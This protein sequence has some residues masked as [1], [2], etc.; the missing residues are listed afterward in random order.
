MNI[1]AHSIAASDSNIS[2]IAGD[3]ERLCRSI[4]PLS[5]VRAGDL[6]FIG[7]K[8]TPE[9]IGGAHLAGATAVCNEAVA[10]MI[11][12]EQDV[13]L[14]VTANARLAFMRAARTFFTHRGPAAG[15]HPSAV[16]AS[17]AVVDPTAY[18]GPGVVVGAGSRIGPDAII[19]PN[20]V[21]YDRVTIG[22]RVI[23]NAGTV[24][25]AD[26]F[27]YERNEA[28]ELEKFPHLGGVVIEDD[29][30]IGS[31]TSIDRGTLGDTV[32]R[33]R[34]RIDNQVHIAHNVVVGEDA[35]I[36]A[37]AMVGGSVVIG[38]RAW[39]APAAVVMNQVAVGADATIGLGA[40][41]VK[42]VLD[43]QTVMGSPA[44]PDAE[45]KAHRKALK[46]LLEA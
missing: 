1:S 16:V 46:A 24:I 36:I 22:A 27:G 8:A 23:V 7:S 6:T 32:I 37:Q 21:I 31:N 14:L 5:Q 19:H 43:G 11:G 28:G 3:A 12:P 18:I 33:Q 38:P 42:M 10:A 26:G 40:V 25:G 30:E 35:A 41:V 17:D 44:I 13:T 34:A 4:S 39:L 45:F 2:R 20:V 9:A 29:V 15:V